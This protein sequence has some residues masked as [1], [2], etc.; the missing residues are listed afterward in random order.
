MQRF[1]PCT[2]CGNQVLTP[3]LPAGMI[4]PQAL[5]CE[6]CGQEF[7][8]ETGTNSDGSEIKESSKDGLKEISLT[9]TEVEPT[10]LDTLEF[11]ALETPIEVEAESIQPAL[12]LEL[13][14]ELEEPEEFEE[15]E[16]PDEAGFTEAKISEQQSATDWSVLGPPIKRRR[17]QE[18][19]AIRKILPP[20]LGGLA[21]F[22][23]ATLIMWY[24][25]GKDIGSTGPT[26]AQYVP[27]IVPQK[28]RN[29]PWQ[30]SAR[31]SR[32]DSHL[33]QRSQRTAPQPRT[34]FPTLNR[35]N[36]IVEP[37]DRVTENTE[38]TSVEKTNDSVEKPTMQP[39]DD[40]P[41]KN[42]P[43]KSNDEP[44]I[45]KPS[46]SETI[47]KLRTLQKEWND[48]P[49]SD[50]AKMVGEY[51]SIVRQL[52]EQAAELKGRSASVWRKEL[53][54]ISRE[55]LSHSNIPR[56]I[57]LGAMGKLP[58]VPTTRPDDFFATVITIG[59]VN[60][61]TSNASW[62]LQEKWSSGTG[63]IPIEIL[64]GAWRAGAATLPATCL[65]LGQ[66]V[67]IE[68]S[69]TDSSTGEAIQAS[70][71]LKVHSLLPK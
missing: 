22:P 38:L 63:E 60:E 66:L 36:T 50:Q 67:A 58:G 12:E 10:E 34:S 27:W 64:P 40:K 3:E 59:D 61:P 37:A 24:G 20:V 48:T 32:E 56:A 21:A 31:G 62:I 11:D 33:P 39:D 5:T 28:L 13:E 69:E 1:V 43:T 41:L 18:A 42:D 55:I 6:V 49:K 19:S 53:E 4:V 44:T 25:F 57:Q 30:Y 47:A 26:V 54:S 46:L 51:F 8:W 15:A 45:A 2:G 65:A 29:T 7:L 23:I 52:S 9:A 16:A 14:L 17:A 35:E 70:V 71:I 68:A